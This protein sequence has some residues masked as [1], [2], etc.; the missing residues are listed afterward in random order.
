MEKMTLAEVVRATRGK[1]AGRG[2]G[3][4]PVQGI[5][6][7]SRLTQE[8]ELFFALKG[9]RYDGHDFVEQAFQRG[10]KAAV[11]SRN[12]FGPNAIRV[13]DTLSALG[14]LASH[15]R[16]RFL[17]PVVA[18]TGSNGKTTTKDLIAAVLSAR[19]KVRKTQGNLNNLI[20]LPLSVFALR[21]EDEVAVLEMGASRLGEIGRLARIADPLVGVVTNVGPVHLEFFKTIENVARAKSELIG[22]LD[23]E[24]HAVLNGDDQYCSLMQKRSRAEVRTFGL[25]ESCQVRAEEIEGDEETTRFKVRGLS[26]HTALLGRAGVYSCL[27]AMCVGEIFGIELR[28]MLGPVRDFSP[29]PMRLEKLKIGGVLIVNDTYNSNP[30]SAASSLEILSTLR[31]RRRIAVLGDMLELGEEWRK[32]HKQLGER[33]SESSVDWLFTV[34]EGGENIARGALRKGKKMVRSFSDN[35]EVIRFLQEFVEPG[36]IYLV[37]GS[38]GMRMEEIVSGMSELLKEI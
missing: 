38:R 28:Q 21:Q 8:G 14:D 25:G 17:V 5:S 29:P 33:V 27:A 37:K 6:T 13:D 26:F 24:G 7:D 18:V 23:E 36:D 32:L 34:G 35:Q 10:A 3:N 9:S 4:D 22:W 11:V 16:R 19:F 15:Y 12:S 31:G 2:Q 1:L 20:G 30:V